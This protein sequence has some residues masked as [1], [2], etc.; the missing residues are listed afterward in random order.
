MV[1]RPMLAP[2]RVASCRPSSSRDVHD[3]WV[4]DQRV[5]TALAMRPGPLNT[6]TQWA[7]P[8]RLLPRRVERPP[9]AAQIN[10]GCDPRPA[11][12]DA[13]GPDDAEVT[14]AGRRGFS[15]FGVL[16]IVAPC[17]GHGAFF[18]HRAGS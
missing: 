1:M 15:R 9:F 4:G 13:V 17:E 11:H 16:V 10:R 3:A 2:G 6:K 14:A 18:D 5:I 12:A 8:Q 7:S